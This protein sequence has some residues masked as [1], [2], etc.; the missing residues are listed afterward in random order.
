VQVLRLFVMLFS[1]PLLAR[2][3]RPRSG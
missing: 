1:A 3:L 2:V